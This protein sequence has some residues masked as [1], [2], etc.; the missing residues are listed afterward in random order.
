MSDEELRRA[1]RDALIGGHEEQVKKRIQKLRHNKIVYQWAPDTAYKVWKAK[2]GLHLWVYT[3]HQSTASP[4]CG[5]PMVWQVEDLIQ[6]T[7][8]DTA[9]MHRCLKCAI[10]AAKRGI[11]PEGKQPTIKLTIIDSANGM[12]GGF[13]DQPVTDEEIAIMAGLTPEE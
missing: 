11:P 2:N 9:Q 3:R 7:N 8:T 1:N 12:G 13:H 10:K 4:C 6:R 5:T